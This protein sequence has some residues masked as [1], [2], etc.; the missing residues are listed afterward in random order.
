MEFQPL[1]DM[2]LAK[3]LVDLGKID[4]DLGEVL[5]QFGPPPMW[6]R[7]PGFPTLV[8][9]ILEQQVSL[10]SA[11]A[12]FDK[13]IDALDT[14]TPPGFLTLDADRLKQIGFSRQKT[15]YCRI[16][17]QTVIDGTLDLPGLAGKNPDQIS[18]ELTAVTGIGR[19]TA[20]IYLLMALRHPDVWPR[21]DLALCSAVQ[22]VKKLPS[23]PSY[24]ELDVMSEHWRPWRSVAARIFWHYYLSRT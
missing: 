13:L 3:A 15:R 14:L 8:K 20:D 21:G 5:S 19:W 7:D 18:D 10:A 12:A 9:I 4:P 24:E 2:T 16:L 17:A 22:R 1:T 23:R 11:Q 6:A